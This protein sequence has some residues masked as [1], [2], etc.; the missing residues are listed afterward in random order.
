[1]S[2]KTYTCSGYGKAR[3]PIQSDEETKTLQEWM[4]DASVRNVIQQHEHEVSCWEWE[5]VQP[6]N[7][8][9]LTDGGTQ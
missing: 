4:T 9:P 8:A 7:K 2:Q 1:M 3:P 6:S 5:I